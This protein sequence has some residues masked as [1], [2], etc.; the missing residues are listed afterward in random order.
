MSVTV[1]I[2]GLQA[3]ASLASEGSMTAAARA[4]GYTPSAVSQQISKLERDVHQVLVEQNGRVATLSAARRIVADAVLITSGQP[5][6][7]T[8]YWRLGA[9]IFYERVGL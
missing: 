9:V 2:S 7:L 5:T 8:R 6:S 1:S 4:L 3:I